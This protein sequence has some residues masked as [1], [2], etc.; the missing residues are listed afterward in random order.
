MQAD[1]YADSPPPL[2]TMALAALI[3]GTTA[4]VGVLDTKLR[5]LYVNPALE[6][7]NGVPAA[8]HLGRTV[9]EVLPEVDA[10][11]DLMLAVLSDGR[12]REITSSGRTPAMSASARRYWHG[13]YHRLEVAYRGGGRRRHPAGGHGLRRG[14]APAGPGPAPSESPGQCEHPHRHHARHGHHLRRAG[15]PR[16][17]GARRSR[18]GRG[19]PAGRRPAGASRTARGDPTEA[20]GGD[21]GAEAARA[22]R[23]VRGG[24]RLRRLP[25][26]SG[27]DALS[28]HQP[29]GHREPDRG[30]ATGPRRAL[31]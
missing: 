29:A 19:L 23:A 12:S 9:A 3:G 31:P 21:G 28:G 8:D 30:R 20:G 24:R 5:Y 17:P 11:E 6:R 14:A 7:L 18:H 2:D 22:G 27:G 15:R 4:G 16:R 25:G 1:V 26:G 10:R 13:A